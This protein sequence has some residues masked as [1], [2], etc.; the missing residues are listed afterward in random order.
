MGLSEILIADLPGE[1]V[2]LIKRL[3]EAGQFSAIRLCQLTEEE[4]ALRLRGISSIENGI[5][6]L[7]TSQKLLSLANEKGVAAIAYQSPGCPKFLHADMVVEGF[8]EVDAFFLRRVYERKH[9]IPWQ[10]A[11]TERCL[12]RELSLEDV[13]ELLQLYAEPG[14]TDYMKGLHPP[15]EELAFQRAYIEHQY[16][17]IRDVACL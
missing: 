14:I 6:F 5:I 4:A 11:E 2:Q 7:S 17:R 8:E 1:E 3:A 15:G 9:G 10:I 12:I 16:L 13:P